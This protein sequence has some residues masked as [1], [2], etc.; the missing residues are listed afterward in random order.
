MGT[1]EII[2]NEIKKLPVDKRIAIVEQTL[3]SIRESEGEKRL[4]DAVEALG[5]DYANDKELTA[6]T[7]IDFDDFYET[8]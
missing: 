6:F 1:T 8:R 7:G 5:G 2:I 4:E 3:K